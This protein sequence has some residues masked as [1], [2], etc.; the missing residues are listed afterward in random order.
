MKREI[1][2]PIFPT[3][4][5]IG[6]YL[7]R[8]ARTF[9]KVSNNWELGSIMC[10]RFIS[11]T[12]VQLSF[13]LFLLFSLFPSF[14]VLSSFLTFPTLSLI[15]YFKIPPLSNSFHSLNSLNSIHSVHVFHPILYLFTL[16]SLIYSFYSYPSTSKFVDGSNHRQSRR[17]CRHITNIITIDIFLILC[18]R[19]E[20]SVLKS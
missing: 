1:T 2:K 7:T 4:I 17:L 11:Y 16:C 13:S 14:P 12:N 15:L 8:N 5:F 19:F 20:H 18:T 6:I 10:Y 3:F 9:A